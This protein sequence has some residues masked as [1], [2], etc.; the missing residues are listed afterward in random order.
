LEI[1]R[2]PNAPVPLTFNQFMNDAQA[3][4]QNYVF[5]APGS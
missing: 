4:Q 1:W 2:Q 3:L 5:G